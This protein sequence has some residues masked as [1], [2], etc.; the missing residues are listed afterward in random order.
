MARYMRKYIGADTMI[1]QQG[2]MSLDSFIVRGQPLQ[3]KLI[4]SGLK[5]RR[6]PSWLQRSSPQGVYVAPYP[7]V[8]RYRHNDDAVIQPGCYRNPPIVGWRAHY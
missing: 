6:F 7:C 8:A 2:G 1:R 4:A 5:M 3:G